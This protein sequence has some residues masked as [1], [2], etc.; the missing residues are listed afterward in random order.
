MLSL[1]LQIF[2]SQLPLS[3]VRR[4]TGDVAV[5]SLCMGVCRGERRAFTRPNR[6]PKNIVLKPRWGGLPQG[7]ERLLE[8][9]SLSCSGSNRSV[10]QGHLLTNLL[11]SWRLIPSSQAS[12][13]L[14]RRITR[15]TRICTFSSSSVAWLQ[16]GCEKWSRGSSKLSFHC[17]PGPLH[18]PS[19]SEPHFYHTFWLWAIQMT[20]RSVRYHPCPNPRM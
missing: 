19:W 14:C 2:Q 20:G 1:K 17:L 16:V 3:S 8:S 13:E 5:L 11:K 18:G 4:L 7:R 9:A 15:I 6:M 10:L 12:L